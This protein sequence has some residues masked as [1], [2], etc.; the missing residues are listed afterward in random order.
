MERGPRPGPE[1]VRKT[2][3]YGMFA[4]VERTPYTIGPSGK[5][6]KH[7]SAHVLVAGEIVSATI[8]PSGDALGSTRPA[9]MTAAAA[10]AAAADGHDGYGWDK[11]VSE[12]YLGVPFEQAKNGA[13]AI[14]SGR[15]LEKMAIAASLEA[16][17]TIFQHDVDEAYRL[18]DKVR[19]GLATVVVVLIDSKGKKSEIKRE[20]AQTADQIIKELEEKEA[21]N[22]GQEKQ[23]G[24]QESRAQDIFTWNEND[25]ALFEA[26]VENS[27]GSSIVEKVLETV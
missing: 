5:T 8:I 22:A 23:V 1:I 10:A 2:T 24:L 18:A 25:Q 21:K 20:T 19:K 4:S 7:E 15:D 9:R 13:S 6:A 3:K 14:L 16:N 26:E 17:G 11:I 27:S 12:Y